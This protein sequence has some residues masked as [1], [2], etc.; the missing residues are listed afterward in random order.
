MTTVKRC[1]AQLTLSGPWGYVDLQPGMPVDLARVLTPAADAV[2]AK[3]DPGTDGY[4]AARAAVREFTVADAV[5]GREECF[6]DLEAP[7]S[8]SGGPAP[9][10]F[11]A[12]LVP[13]ATDFSTATITPIAP[14][15]PTP[16]QE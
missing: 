11:K 1:L 8:L 9:A 13:P 2:A 15:A 16:Q 14:A 10:D 7:I 4:V 12:T 5:E 3:G 6:E